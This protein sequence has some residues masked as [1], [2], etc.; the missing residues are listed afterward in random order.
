MTNLAGIVVIASGLLGLLATG[1]PAREKAQ[2]GAVRIGLI[3]TLFRDVDESKIAAAVILFQ[4]LLEAQTG[5]TGEPLTVAT[6]DGLG[7]KLSQAS[8]NLGVFHGIE[9]AWAKQ[10]YPGLRPLV[11]AVNKQRLLHAFLVVRQDDPAAKLSDLK[12]KV[13]ALPHGSR[14][15]SRLFL[16]RHCKRCGQEPAQFF[17][18]LTDPPS[19]E[20]GLDDVVDGVA[21]VTVVDGVS[22]ECFKQRKP[23][24][25]A[26]LKVLEKSEAFPA[27]VLAYH[28]GSLDEATLKRIRDGLIS[29]N[30]N[31]R[32][33]HLLMLWKL[34]GFEPIPPDFDQT[35]A[36]IAKAY[37]PPETASK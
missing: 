3:A 33:R 11:I 4:S 6:P 16:E 10:K 30:Q 35:V 18:K 22:L 19:V 1:S 14:E 15:H 8:V 17:A 29:A 37:P 24:R 7:E 31:D 26:Q 13:G 20:D 32:G 27:A 34:T 23:A 5:L 25:F 9:Y 12:G 21:Q 36:N 28:T 2:V